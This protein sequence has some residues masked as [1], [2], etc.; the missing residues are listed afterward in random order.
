MRREHKCFQRQLKNHSGRKLQHNVDCFGFNLMSLNPH[1]NFKKFLFQNQD[2]KISTWYT[3]DFTSFSTHNVNIKKLYNVI[4]WIF[5]TFCQCTYN[6]NYRPLPSLYAGTLA[7]SVCIWFVWTTRKNTK[8]K[9]SI[10]LHFIYCQPSKLN[11][12]SSL[13]KS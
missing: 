7:K 4:F 9:N 11:F 1:P 8:N 2:K 3:I 13:G 12:T 5:F 6:K 10:Y